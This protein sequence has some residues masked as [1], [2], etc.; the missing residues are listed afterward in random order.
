ME[1]VLSMEPTYQK[2]YQVLSL[3]LDL[4]FH[5]TRS[6]LAYHSLHDVQDE[7]AIF[8]DVHWL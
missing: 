7:V 6:L 3:D 5:E 8:A 1:V 4:V 2:P